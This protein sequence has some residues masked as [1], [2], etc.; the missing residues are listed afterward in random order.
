VVGDLDAAAEIT[1]RA[2]MLNPNLA[3][4]WRCS[5]FVKCYI[6]EP[7]VAIEH[8]ARAMRLN[9]L[10]PHNFLVQ[11]GTALAH[12]F[13]GRYEEASSWAHR[14]I[15]RQPNHQS[16]LRVYAASNALAGRAKEAQT[17]AT[18][19]RQVD[20]AFRVSALKDLVPLRRPEDL[21][22]FSDG[23]RKAGLPE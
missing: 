4:A 12:L 17:T 14:A 9:P 15:Q 8:L 18:R 2:L 13:A 3:R 10:D 16:A 23:L 11:A 21:I 19:I 7:E 20:P 22:R 5:G 1:A 6:G